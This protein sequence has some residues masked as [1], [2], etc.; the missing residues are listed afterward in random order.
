M[1]RRA[2]LLIAPA[3]PETGGGSTAI[4]F[5]VADTAAATADRKA[6]GYTFN[7]EPFDTPVGKFVTTNDPDGKIVGLR[8]RSST[9]S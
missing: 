2:S 4:W 3:T 1:G 5:E 7:E 8:D 6:R 9:V